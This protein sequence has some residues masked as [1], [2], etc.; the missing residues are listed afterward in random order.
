MVSRIVEKENLHALAGRGSRRSGC[1]A[2][3]KFRELE[4]DHYWWEAGR[5]SVLGGNQLHCGEKVAESERIVCQDFPAAELRVSADEKSGN[6]TLGAS[7]P[8]SPLRL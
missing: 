1:A 2:D 3:G 8:D 7:L 5:E 6:G 4:P